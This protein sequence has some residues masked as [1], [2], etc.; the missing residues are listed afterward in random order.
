MPSETR[1]T[2]SDDSVEKF[3]LRGPPHNARI[4]CILAEP[5]KEEA[6]AHDGDATLNGV[7]FWQ[8]DKSGYFQR[9]RAEC[10]AI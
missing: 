8:S 1:N 6:K 3:E 7:S 5:L 10:G 9:G 4:G 2:D